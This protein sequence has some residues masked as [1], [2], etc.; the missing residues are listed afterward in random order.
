MRSVVFAA[1]LFVC[2]VAIQVGNAQSI[3]W[4][5][6]TSNNTSACSGAGSPSYCAEALPTLDTSPTNQPYAQTTTVDAFPVHVSS[7][8]IGQLMKTTSQ[9]WT[10]KVLCEYQPWFSTQQQINYNGHIEIGYDENNQTTVAMQD[11]DM[12]SRGCN[13]NFID[14]Y[15]A[16]NHGFNLTSSDNVYSDLS[17]RKTQ[18]GYPMQIGILEDENAFMAECTGNNQ[19]HDEVVA[20]IESSLESDMDYVYEN[21]IH[22][23]GGLYWMDS[24]SG[25]STNVVGFFGACG[26]FAVNNVQILNCPTDWATIWS[27]VWGYANTTKGYHMEFIFEYGQFDEPSGYSAGVYAWPQPYTTPQCKSQKNCFISNKPSQFYWCDGGILCD[28]NYL[29]GAY[30][31]RFYHDASLPQN[32][33]YIAVGLVDS[34]FDDSNAGWGY[35]RVVA[36]QCGQVLWD[37]ANEMSAGGYWGLGGHQIPYMQVATWNDYEEATE[38]ESG[39]N[40]CYTVSAYQ[41]V[42]QGTLNWT[43]SPSDSVYANQ[44]TIDHFTVWW[45]AHSSN[46]NKPLQVAAT[47]IKA[48]NQNGQYSIDL[49]TLNL[50]HP[51]PDYTVDLYVEMVGIPSVLNQM[52]GVV[53]YTY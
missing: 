10:G 41:N 27:F 44:E 30:L 4:A 49:S 45:S 33:N 16:T 5:S 43:L 12:I 19:T 32:A 37:T 52:S 13:I 42:E 24:L 28:G 1:L 34:G 6:E 3:T 11:S 21:Y 40:N 9:N 29:S 15:G 18:N 53:S 25:Q 2:L 23:A 38:Q 22:P 14:F 47:N 17:A 31:D 51:A 26:D 35:D 36:Q 7:V 46:P 48:N 39:I 20:C 8:Q 50:P